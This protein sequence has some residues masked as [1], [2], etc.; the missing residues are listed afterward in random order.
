MN[1]W[2]RD[3]RQRNRRAIARAITCLESGE[4][5]QRT[6]LLE[7]L[8]PHTGRAWVIGWTGP[9]GAGKSTLTDRMIRHLR[10][11]GWTVGV[12]AV[13]PTSP[14]TGG[15]L[16]G[17]RVRMTAHALDEGVFIRSM[18]SRGSLGGLSRATGEA[19]RVLDAAG[20]DV[21]FVE[22]V[23]VGQSEVDIMH[24]AD[25]VALVV[26]PGA[27]D[28]IQVF[29]AGIMEIADLFVVNKADLDGAR[30]LIAQ[31]E[32]MLDIAKH[33]HAWRPPIVPTVSTRGQGMDLLWEALTAHRDFLEQSGEW[34]R[35]R[36]RRLR[37]E[38]LAIMEQRLH[39]ELQSWLSRPEAATDLDRVERREIGPHQVA[40]QWWSRI[41]GKR[42]GGDHSE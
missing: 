21:I 39:R 17:D 9:P 8:Y 27:G 12:I 13:D 32:E 1:A 35:R 29:K 28:T 6:A 42:D 24:M 14:F 37:R 3:I 25:T 40:D 30:K 15:A 2:V 10:E 4:E 7:A 20:Y 23:G 31:L 11:Q 34:N 22:T 41:R 16:L 26:T 5:Q 19:V 33:D 18:G 36:L 38:V